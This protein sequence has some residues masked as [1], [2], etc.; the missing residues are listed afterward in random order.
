MTAGVIGLTCE[1]SYKVK[2]GSVGGSIELARA[3][4]VMKRFEHER[5]A[6][7][8]V[9]FQAAVVA[10]AHSERI[11]AAGMPGRTCPCE[12]SPPIAVSDRTPCTQLLKRNPVER[13]PL[14]LP[15][16]KT[17]QKYPR[18]VISASL[19][20]ISRDEGV[21]REMGYSVG[22]TDGETDSVE[23]LAT[24]LSQAGEPCQ[25]VYIASV[26]QFCQPAATVV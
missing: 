4:L 18:G 26:S 21:F 19:N 16:S 8:C 10:A 12:H 3:S 20:F 1:W 25:G 13:I 23:H 11:D 9:N 24:T 14:R 2:I 5:C 17:T 6:N 7:V 22:V 15:G